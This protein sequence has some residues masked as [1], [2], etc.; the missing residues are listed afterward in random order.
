MK[1]SAPIY[2]LRAKAKSLKKSKS[3]SLAEALNEVAKAE[4][5]N[6]WSLLQSKAKDL[7]PKM[8]EDVLDYLNP[9]DLMLIA[10]RPGLRKTTFTL[11]ILIQAAK[12]KRKCFF[13]SLEYTHKDVASKM[14]DLDESIGEFNNS[15]SFDYSNDISSAY[16]KR[17]TKGKLE[18]GSIIG[19]DYLQ[20]LD[21]KRSN[22]EL[23]SQVEELK[24]FA[25]EEGCIILFISQVDRS[26][27]DK[28][29]Q[30]PSLNDLRLPNPL[31]LNLFNKNM[32]L[33][34]GELIFNS[35]PEYNLD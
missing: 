31:D 7:I 6:S 13:F 15:L 17:F 30:K 16:I 5:F 19:I 26:F 24:E 18:K 11:Q 25:K 35:S 20:L 21:Q 33:H 28:S 3:I 12:E 10:S 14:A 22:P 29:T 9:G 34:N 32:F 8:R 4:G 23:Q 1:L 27:E 2:V